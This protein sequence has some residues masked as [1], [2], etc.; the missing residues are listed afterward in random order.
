MDTSDFRRLPP[1]VAPD[2][3]VQEVPHHEAV[4]EIHGVRKVS[5]YSPVSGIDEA[6][7]YAAI[8][9]GPATRRRRRIAR[10]IVYVTLASYLVWIT[11]SAIWN[12]RAV[13]G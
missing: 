12:A 9:T 13:L 3:T 7:V 10:T 5:P 4:G 6:R 2:E 8:A 1:R 11:V